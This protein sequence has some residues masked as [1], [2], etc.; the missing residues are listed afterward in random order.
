M[1]QQVIE[2]LARLADERGELSFPDAVAD[3]VL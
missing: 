3:V 1:I 2:H